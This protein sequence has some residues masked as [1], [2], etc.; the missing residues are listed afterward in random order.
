MIKEIESK[1]NKILLEKDFTDSEVFSLIKKEIDKSSKKE[2]LSIDQKIAMADKIYSRIKGFGILDD[3]LSDDTV[4]EIMIN[5]Y[6]RIFIEQNGKLL[7]SPLQFE[8]KKQLEDI[9]FK[10][11]GK[12]GREINT[13]NPIVDIRLCS[14][15]R[16][17]VVIE[18]VVSTGPT[19]TIRK[20]PEKAINAKDL[21]KN[22]TVTIEAMNFLEKLV[23]TK[24]NI[25]ISG[26]T[27]AGKTTLLN[28]LTNFIGEK[29]RIV[30]IEDSAEIRLNSKIKNYVSMEVR[31]VN[32]AGVGEITVRDLIKT[33][34]RMRPERIIVGEVRGAEAI[35]M[36]QAM[37]TG[38]EGSMSTGHS[39]SANDMFSRLETMILQ[40]YDNIP[41]IAIKDMIASSIDIV[42]HISRM[43][44]FSRHITE[45][46]EVTGHQNGKIS[47]NPIYLFK[48]DEKSKIDKVSGKLVRTDRPFINDFKLKLGGF[49][50]N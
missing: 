44:D 50:E 22:N 28:V 11:V 17:N 38:H 45:I 29:E 49:Y 41:L 34:L 33:S 12:A 48:E 30:L 7:L 19:V 2:Y 47:L 43:R 9:V 20:F 25:F 40:S 31:Q 46:S 27:S 18:P 21:I 32:S 39:N 10:M 14:G 24:Y 3:L 8:S 6:N 42:V 37:N 5:G 23:K 1:I 13:A 35:D 15:E 16:V 36:L 26:G 4:S